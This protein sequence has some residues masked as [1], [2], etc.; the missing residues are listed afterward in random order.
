MRRGGHGR[1]QEFEADMI[2]AGKG[3]AQVYWPQAASLASFFTD[4][5][6]RD[7]AEVFPLGFPHQKSSELTNVLISL[8]VFDDRATFCRSFTALRLVAAFSDG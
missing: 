6:H 7:L 4:D 1:D 3:G 8:Y 5:A 2:P